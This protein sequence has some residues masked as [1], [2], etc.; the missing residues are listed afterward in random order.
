MTCSSAVLPTQTLSNFRISLEAA[1]HKCW[2]IVDD[3][4][5]VMSLFY[6]SLRRKK[7]NMLQQ[8]FTIQ[9]YEII[10]ETPVKIDF[11]FETTE[12]QRC[13]DSYILTLKIL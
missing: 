12:I 13:Q 3:A 1:T 4:H 2:Q 7:K 9:C 11:R 8:E 5:F 10:L 6:G